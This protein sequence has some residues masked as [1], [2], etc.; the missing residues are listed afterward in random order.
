MGLLIGKLVNITFLDILF[1][2]LMYPNPLTKS[3]IVSKHDT[4]KV[5]SRSARDMF[6][7]L[8]IKS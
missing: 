8:I 1:T 2:L 3:D 7:H 6:N 5:N 4:V